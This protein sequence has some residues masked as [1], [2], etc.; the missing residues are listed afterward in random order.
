M[1]SFLRSQQTL[2]YSRRFI[3]MFTKSPPLVPILTQIH[4]VHI[5]PLYFP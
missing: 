5:F 3:T 2:S 4:P 1:A